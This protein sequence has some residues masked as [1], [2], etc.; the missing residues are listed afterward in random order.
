M[1]EALSAVQHNKKQSHTGARGDS[2]GQTLAHKYKE[3]PKRIKPGVRGSTHLTCSACAGK[4]TW[5]LKLQKVTGK[6]QHRDPAPN[7]V[8]DKDPQQNKNGIIVT[9]Q[10]SGDIFY[11]PLI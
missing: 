6:E 1:C 3:P 5:R 11:V 4:G 7:M 8:E 10:I 2:V 9:H